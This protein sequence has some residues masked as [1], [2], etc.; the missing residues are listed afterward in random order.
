ME[1]QR[2]FADLAWVVVSEIAQ[3]LLLLLNGFEHV[4]SLELLT[5]KMLKNPLH[6]DSSDQL[7]A[8]AFASIFSVNF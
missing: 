1:L 3:T 6:I 2:I 7:D 8:I 5:C 4:G